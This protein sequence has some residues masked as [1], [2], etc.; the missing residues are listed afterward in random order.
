MQC[1]KKCTCASELPVSLDCQHTQSYL[2]ALSSQSAAQ[3]CYFVKYVNVSNCLSS[4]ILVICI[5]ICAP[6]SWCLKILHWCAR[7]LVLAFCCTDNAELAASLSFAIGKPHAGNVYDTCPQHGSRSSPELSPYQPQAH[8][9]SN[10]T[11]ASS[12]RSRAALTLFWKHLLPGRDCRSGVH[13]KH[14]SKKVCTWRSVHVAMPALLK[15]C[16]AAL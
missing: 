6:K 12:L 7:F 11:S 15:G 8:S 9:Y 2:L 13:R 5:S 3:S 14:R 16:R 1:N 4:A 10:Q